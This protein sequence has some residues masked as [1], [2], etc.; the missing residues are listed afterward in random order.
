MFF[1]VSLQFDT[2]TA[3]MRLFSKGPKPQ[4]CSSSVTSFTRRSMRRSGLSV[5]NS[6]MARR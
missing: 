3:L 5:P 2:G 1:R 4:F 6:S